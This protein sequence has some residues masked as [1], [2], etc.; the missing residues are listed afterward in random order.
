MEEERCKDKM[1]GK[2]ERKRRRRKDARIRCTG[3]KK[4]KDGG[5]K[6]QG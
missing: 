6:M 3:R 5:G 4:E 2:E 1:H